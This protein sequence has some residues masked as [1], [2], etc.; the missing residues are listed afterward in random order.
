MRYPL[1]TDAGRLLE[2]SQRLVVELERDYGRAGRILRP[3]I[4]ANAVTLDLKEADTFIVTLTANLS[5]LTA[6]LPRETIERRFDWRLALVQDGTGGR[7]V[8]FPGGWLW[9]GGGNPTV[10]AAANAIDIFDLT[11]IDSVH[12]GRIFGQGLA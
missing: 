7:T 1:L 8:T 3:A 6:I 5:T 2:W 12:H 4:S 10:T 9:P 11:T